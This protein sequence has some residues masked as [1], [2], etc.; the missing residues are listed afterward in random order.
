MKADR[1]EMARIFG[2]WWEL[3]EDLEDLPAHEVVQKLIDL[4]KNDD[5]QLNLL[6]KRLK[7]TLKTGGDGKKVDVL[8]P[9]PIM[10]EIAKK[11]EEEKAAEAIPSP[12]PTSKPSI[13]ISIYN[14]EYDEDKPLTAIKDDAEK[15]QSL[16]KEKFRY[17]VRS[18]AFLKNIKT[19][20]KLMEG[21]EKLLERVQ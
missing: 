17:E 8:K 14:D 13:V 12:I 19:G 11:G 1:S 15:F 9:N 4:F 3:D 16:L 20:E 5:I 6:A 2:D 7:K 21:F 10:Q 18:V